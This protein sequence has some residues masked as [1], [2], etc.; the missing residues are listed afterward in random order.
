MYILRTLTLKTF[1]EEG[2]LP[3][4]EKFQNFYIIK[5]A[6][7][8]LMSRVLLKL[9]FRVRNLIFVPFHINII[10]GHKCTMHIKHL[11][12][13]STGIYEKGKKR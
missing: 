11:L 3:Y 6:F 1:P 8:Y 4:P 2:A 9:L 7:Y 5:E 10:N 13:V 12:R